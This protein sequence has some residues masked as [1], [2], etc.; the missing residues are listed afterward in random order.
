[1]NL[2]PFV[3]SIGMIL[4]QSH[5]KEVL[6]SHSLIQLAGLGVWIGP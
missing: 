2:H 4:L 3:M 5:S 1:M 6:F